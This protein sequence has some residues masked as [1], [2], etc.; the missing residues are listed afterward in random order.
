MSSDFPSEFNA[1]ASQFLKNKIS[2]ADAK[3]I[4]IKLSERQNAE[5]ETSPIGFHLSSVD[6]LT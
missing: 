6:T 2:F 4:L 1:L 5:P 3:L